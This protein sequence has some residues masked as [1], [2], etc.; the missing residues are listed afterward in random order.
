MAA[1]YFTTGQAAR[2]LG[3]SKGT[4]L[5]AVA[6][7]ELRATHRMPGGAYRFQAPEVERYGHWR[8]VVKHQ[9]EEQ[10]RAAVRARAQLAVLGVS[11]EPRI[12]P[13]A[14]AAEAAQDDASTEIADIL[15]LLAHSLPVGATLVLRDE[16]GAWL[17]AYAYDRVGMGMQA[18]KPLPWPETFAVA[19][20]GGPA[21]SLIVED[22][23]TDA[24]LSAPGDQRIWGV[25]TVTA[26]PLHQSD[27]QLY[28]V[29]CTLHP[30]PR[31]VPGGEL[32][33]L[34]LAGRMVLQ[35][36]AA[37]ALRERERHAA[38]AQELARQRA[39]QA[40]R[41]REERCRRIIETAQEG[42]WQLDFEGRTTFINQRIC[43]M[44]GYSAEEILG[45]FPWEFEPEDGVPGALERQRER[46]GGR[47]MTWEILFVRKDGQELW[48]RTHSFALYDEQGGV[49]GSIGMVEDI[50]NQRAAE[51]ATARLAAMV[52]SF[53]DAIIGTSASNVIESWNEGAERLYG[54]SAEEVIGRHVAML[55]S[56]GRQDEVERIGRQLAQGRPILQLET[57]R[58]HK[59]GQ[60]IDVLLTVSPIR[61]AAGAVI[62]HA[63][64]TRDLQDRK[65]AEMA[66]RKSE[67]EFRLLAENSSDMIVRFTPDLVVLYASPAARQLIG[68]EPSGLVGRQGL[69]FIH[70]DD[71]DRVKHALV[72]V[73]RKP[74]ANAISY[75][76]LRADGSYVWVESTGRGIRD[77]STGEVSEIQVTTRDIT[78]RRRTEDTLREVA[79]ARSEQ[80]AIAEALSE[81]S[82]ALASV[83]EPEPMYARI[84]AQMARVVPCTGAYIFAYRGSSVVVAGAYG[85]PQPPEGQQLPPI[86]G[87]EGLLGPR[88]QPRLLNETRYTPGWQ[89]LAPWEGEYEVRSTIILPLVVHGETYGCLALASSAPNTYTQR[90][91]EVARA[92]SERCVQALWNARQYQL[93]QKRARIAEQLAELR[94]DF[95]ATVSHELR[96]PLTAVLGYAEV[97]D[98]HWSQLSEAQRRTNLQRIVL[99]ANRQKRLIDDLLRVST[100]ESTEPTLHIQAV[101]LLRVVAQA[102]DV[103][104]ASYGNQ[105][106][107]AAGPPDLM[108]LADAAHVEQV[109]I[110]LLDNAAKYSAEGSP[111]EVSWG[112]EDGMRL[113]R[114]R[115]HGPGIP[116]EGRSMLFTRFGRVPGSRMR[117]GRVGTGLG[118]YLG[119]EYARAMG[120]TLELESTGPCG[121]VFCLRLPA[122]V[123]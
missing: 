114:V 120:G 36:V 21:A 104:H 41:Q 9:V 121:S 60:D 98:A 61:D 16:G 88:D 77:A 93:E 2:L 7:G 18:G 106:I 85:E 116:E 10:I 55:A 111:I 87:P 68:F 90:H 35:A 118:L 69:E 70:P 47:H 99:A 59:D 65:R 113:V 100:F 58:R 44:L 49:V 1:E 29:L 31:M 117:A 26:V 109:L 20:A 76:H 27:G 12:E 83:L 23:R 105:P 46:Q 39:E 15:A 91:L 5:N 33:I 32:S 8:V 78:E 34:R 74:E 48:V 122:P 72:E 13:L 101:P 115:D 92:F 97:L 82:A 112:T 73:Q 14:A 57:V 38:A 54:Y 80:A 110:N 63:S 40:L 28:G 94:N 86:S 25:G 30:S 22:A 50:T 123:S 67:E 66:L 6:A 84:L 45:R 11:T 119:R 96:T 108:A 64:L 37:A 56:A 52:Q 107:D 24:R 95:V 81:A 79:Q 89:V 102:V 19:L 103:V 17:V 51:Q 71:V 4:V 43:E 42:V 3:V 62:G 53:P 75:R